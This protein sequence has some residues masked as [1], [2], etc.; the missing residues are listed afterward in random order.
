MQITMHIIYGI[1]NA[2]ARKRL[3]QITP[4]PTLTQ[5]LL[6]FRSTE[7]TLKNVSLPNDTKNINKTSEKRSARQLKCVIGAEISNTSPA[8]PVQLK[9]S[10]ATAVTKQITSHQFAGRPRKT[11]P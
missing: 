2:E 10:R 1:H 4:F 5:A 8:R 7:T 9:E 6:V 3:L 11:I